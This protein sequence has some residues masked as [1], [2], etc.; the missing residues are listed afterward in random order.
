[1]ESGEFSEL[2][3][4]R[5]FI[6]G[7][8]NYCDRWCERC[9]MTSRCRLFAD[10]QSERFSTEEQDVENEAFWERMGEKFEETIQR[11]HEAAAR[12]RFDIDWEDMEIDDEE[13]DDY[14]EKEERIREKVER[15]PAAKTARAY[16]DRLNEWLEAGEAS[17]EA[18]RKEL[19]A[20]AEMGL[21]ADT[22]AR[23]A[24]DLKTPSRCSAGTSTRS[25]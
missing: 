8:Y 20:Q 23:E 10:F 6:P 1:M 12:R 16:A 24:E 21:D 14:H 22:L 17:F 19:V 7:I 9:P 25:T 11:I 18:K 5:R 3:G 4:S 15:H 2:K 13:L